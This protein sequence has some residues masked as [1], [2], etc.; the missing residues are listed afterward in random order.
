MVRRTFAGDRAELDVEVAGAPLRVRVPDRDAPAVGAAINLT[1][2]SD[3]V[4]VYPAN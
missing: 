1:I 2:V 3:A 4:L